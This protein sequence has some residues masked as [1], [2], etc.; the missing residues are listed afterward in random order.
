MPIRFLLALLL[1][2]SLFAAESST[3]A[4]RGQGLQPLPA[5]DEAA[6]AM[7]RFKIPPGFKIELFA[8]EPMLA[9]PVAFH[10]DE[11]GRV[12]VAETYRHSAVGPA[13]RFLEGVF[14]IRSHMDWLEQDL[15]ARSV[16]DRVALYRR[17]LGTNFARL[18]DISEKIRLLEDRNRDGRADFSSVFAEGFN[19]AA[20]GI[21]AGVLG[22]KG[23]VYYTCIPDLW[24]LGA[25][26][27]TGKATSRQSLHTG[28]G[29]HIAFLGH[30]L[31]GLRIGPDGRLYFSIGDRGVNVMTREG[32]SLVYPDEGTVLRC[33]LDG[34]NLEVFARG[35]RN[36]QELAFDDFGN[37]FTGDNNSDGGDRARWVYVV[38]GGDSGWRIGYQT[39]T[40]PPRRGPWNAERLWH[41][42]HEGQPAYIVP[43]IANLG[44][45]PSGLTYYPGTGLSDQYKG[46]FFLADFRGGASSGLHSFDV[47]PKG[48]SFELGA[49]EQF[50]WESLPTDVDFGVEGGIYFSDWVETWNKTGKGRIYR[51]FNPNSDTNQIAQTKTLLNTTLTNLPLEDLRALLG[52][53][54]QRVRLEAQFAFASLGERGVSQLAAIALSTTN[55]LTAIHA[56]WGLGQ[57]MRQGSSNA[58]FTLL[59]AAR[60]SDPEIR[61]QAVKVLGEATIP[62]AGPIIQPLLADPEPRVRFFAALS[63][64]RLK[65]RS[66]MPALFKLLEENADADPYL[67]HSA[68]MGLAGIADRDAL[69]KA[70]SHSSAS[71]RLGAALAL[72]RLEDPGITAFLNDTNIQVVAE[73]A[74]AI[75]DLPIESALPQLAALL[76]KNFADTQTKTNTARPTGVEAAISSVAVETGITT[77][78]EQILLRAINAHFRLGDKTNAQALANFALKETNPENLRAEALNALGSWANPGGRDRITGL[79]RPVHPRT[80]DAARAALT[81]PPRLMPLFQSQ[82]PSIQIAAIR[83]VRQ[84][85]I[86]SAGFTTLAMRAKDPSV[87]VAALEALAQSEDEKSSLEMALKSALSSDDVALRTVATRLEAEINPAAALQRVRENIESTSTSKKR[88]A[89]QALAVL[90]AGEADNLLATQLDG[91][92]QNKI[93]PELQLDLLDAAGKRQSREVLDRVQRFEAKRAKDDP[94][95]AFTECLQGGS[96]AEGRKL[97]YERAEVFCSRCHQVN[98][99]G[100]EAGPKLTGLG[101]RQSRSYI[102][103]SIVLPNAKFAEGWE[104]VTISLKDGRSFAGKVVKES[105]ATI[106]VNNSE[107]GDVTIN[108]SEIATRN[109]ALSGMPEEFRQI[110]T[111]QE[112]RDLVEFLASQK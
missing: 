97:F 36:P 84:L 58:Q 86:K 29:V 88:N 31:H 87:R 15:A 49:Y 52:H 33:E 93:A 47:R 32:K 73:A 9:N 80:G 14:D 109:R 17:N 83:A 56:I 37:L 82:H 90:P 21:G 60:K 72:R 96:A 24:L 61:A 53:P 71:V 76:S 28:F 68:V 23:N 95:A 110:L 10:I 27:N 105:D 85:K 45:G 22:Y 4:T 63:I 78:P 55:Q 66:A 3:S 42:Q 69:R 111:K 38:E 102:L 112:L 91:L 5:S 40:A 79:W 75:N 25:T 39:L 50:I 101:A 35:L 103:E 108:K 65:H 67:R 13:Y 18:T 70:A 104:N 30:D 44:Y 11:R 41:P 34:S 99:E 77:V 94:L 100:G 98:G 19:R 2:S 59:L 51:V 12:F 92:L 7:K 64:G 89:V 46:R 74:R 1:A 16:E 43:P 20:D 107:D 54:D 26:N 106:V 62:Q 8:A 57:G 6:M 81:P 48:A